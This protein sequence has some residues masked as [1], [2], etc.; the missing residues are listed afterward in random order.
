M[1]LASAGEFTL[2]NGAA[3]R[4]NLHLTVGTQLRATDPGV[5]QYGAILS[6]V[7][8]GVPTGKLSG[9]TGGSDLNYERGKPISTVLKAGFD[10][11]LRKD[12]WGVFVSG[13]AWHDLEQ[14]QRAVRYGNYANHFTPNTPLSDAGFSTSAKFSGVQLR[15][16]YAHG[17][18]HWGESVNLQTRVGRQLLDWGGS[19]LTPGGLNAAIHAV[20][21]AA[22][23]RPGALPG[24][25]KL[26]LGMVHFKLSNH[27]SWQYEGYLALESRKNEIPG[28]GTYFDVSAYSPQGCNF[29]AVGNGTEQ[30]F[31]NAGAY[32][33]RN[34]DVD[35]SGQHGGLAAAY[36]TDSKSTV[37]KWYVLDVAANL[38]TLR[39][40]LNSLPFGTPLRGNYANL[41]LDHTRVYGMSVQSQLSA[42]DK[43]FG[44]LTL[45]PDQVISYNASD[46]VTAFLLG[47]GA[48]AENRSTK[49]VPVGG[50]YDAYE[51]FKVFTGSL[52][53]NKQ[54]A[55]VLGANHSLMI[56]EWAFSHVVGLP[57]TDVVRFGRP[58]AYGNAGYTKA[59][60]SYAA[61]T[62]DTVPGKTC[63]ADGYVTRTA[64]SFR[65]YAALSYA[66]LLDNAVVTPSLALTLD[67]SGYSFDGLVSQG[68]RLVRPGVRVE[69]AQSR[70]VEYQ[71]NRFS[72]GA[73][74]LVADRDFH[75]LVAGVR[76]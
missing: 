63:T 16:V 56:G 72:G 66:N 44:E 61:C 13:L 11:D 53:A 47:S 10:V 76:F 15:E 25:S 75:A 69:W 23:V 35:A 30:A 2:E 55:G 74:N 52:G 4:Y 20:D 17:Q 60:G 64:S 41:Y 73:Y 71:Y 43:V 8:T 26:P 49:S 50:T 29:T 32:I 22:A 45:R 51:R 27:T 62:T 40:T 70:Y 33:H 9:F 5:D 36:T 39:I 38:P 19:Q 67:L 24:E 28:C 58:I 1:T 59:D 68:R 34:P 12:N 18:S 31:Y 7:V 3:G 6:R 65:A 21:Y 42:S 48:L 37:W 54:T 46:L 57:G 14:G